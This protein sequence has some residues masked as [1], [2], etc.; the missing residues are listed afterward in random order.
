MDDLDAY[1]AVS[2]TTD[3]ILFCNYRKPQSN[4]MHKYAQVM[5]AY[6]ELY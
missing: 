2:T 3:I 6:S 4:K 5:I 1:L